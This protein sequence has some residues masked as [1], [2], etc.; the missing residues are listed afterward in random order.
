MI[1]IGIL[2]ALLYYQYYP[3]W[4]TFFH[5]LG[6]EVVVSPLTTQIMLSSGYSR[7]VV[8]TYGKEARVTRMRK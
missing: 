4:P 6:T 8:A 1:R 7:A 2:R 3:M 5:E